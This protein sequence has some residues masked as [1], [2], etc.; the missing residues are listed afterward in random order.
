MRVKDSGRLVEL[1]PGQTVNVLQAEGAPDEPPEVVTVVLA[2]RDWD[3]RVSETGA[4]SS[5][6]ARVAWGLGGVSGTFEVDWTSGTQFSIAADRITVDAVNP[7]ATVTD[8]RNPVQAVQAALAYGTR[9]SGRAPRRTVALGQIPAGGVAPVRTAIP[10]RAHSISLLSDAALTTYA[11]YVIEIDAAP[12]GN[13]ESRILPTA[14]GQW[15][16]LPV[17]ARSVLVTNNRGVADRLTLIYEL[18]V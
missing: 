14:P 2:R 3:S 8:D 13:P 11:D 18:D 10:A 12:A 4:R 16:P 7:D 9:P 15:F 6:F 5:I 17:Q 1:K